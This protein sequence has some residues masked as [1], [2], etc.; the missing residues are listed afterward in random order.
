[1][2]YA[3]YRNPVFRVDIETV[4]GFTKVTAD[5]IL[6]PVLRNLVACE[7]AF[8][9]HQ[10]YIAELNADVSDT[11]LESYFEK[12]GP[13]LIYSTWM[14]PIPSP[15]FERM[16][17][18]RMNAA[19]GTY[20]PEQVTLSVTEECPNRCRHCAL[21]NKNNHSKLTA[22]ETKS[23][24]DQAIA[25][26]ATN[27]IFDGG[28]PLG[29]DGLEEL[30]SY[31]DPNRAIACMFTSGV[32]LTEEKARSLK[33]AGL[34]SVSVSIDSPIGEKHDD[35]RGVSGVF[36]QATTGIK[37]ALAAGLLVNMYV[38]LAPHNV[39]DLEAVYQ[40]AENLGVHELSFYEIVP[41]GR[42]IDNTSDILTA[43]QHELFRQFTDKY[44]ASPAG[45]RIFSGPLIVNEFGC[46]AGRQ[47]LHVTPEGD[48]LP[49][50]C[51]PLPYG[52]IKSGND[53]VRQAWKKI[54]A[55]PAYGKAQGCLMRNPEFREQYGERFR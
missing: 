18:S 2:K 46:M 4:S 39:N 6:S 38:V 31:V 52:N 47:W 27:I 43:E 9:D 32:G 49:C 28:E 55:D 20:R 15:A 10:K 12:Y 51:V 29:Y 36:E 45:P 42:W 8:F 54:R 17:K 25:A 50:S 24:I 48:I 14:P 26:G 34:Y 33:K 5:G 40:L 19:F 44:T 35:M 37:N 21:P 16:V 3:V 23:A 22:E 1:M 11:T 41:T 53:A 7:M 30:V 13:S